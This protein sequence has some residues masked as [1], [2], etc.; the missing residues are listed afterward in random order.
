[1]KRFKTILMTSLITSAVTIFPAAA[2]KRVTVTQ[3]KYAF[4]GDSVYVDM[5]IGL[6]DA[7][8]PANSY[9]LLTPTIQLD[10]IHKE[11][12]SVI[13][14]G[15]KRQKAYE[16]L[17]ALN[18]EPVGAGLVIHPDDNDAHRSYNYSVAVPFEPWMKEADFALREDQ[19]ECNGPLVKMRFDLIV[20]RMQDLNAPEEPKQLFFMA[21]FKAP[22]PEPVK[23]RSEA[24]TAYLDFTLGSSVLKSDFSNN[25][26][27]L[28]K[29]DQMIKTV[30]N[31]P[32]ITITQIIIDGYSS[33]DGP[34][35]LNLSLSGMRAD[36]L[37]EYVSST[38]KLD[39]SLI[40]VTEYG[41]DWKTFEEL[42]IASEVDYKE[43]VLEIINNTDN[44]D[45]RE[46]KLKALPGGA[47]ADI[48]ANFFPKSRRSDYELH[49]IVIPFTVEEGKK[50]IESNPKLLSLN[51]MFLIAASYPVNSDEFHRVF[52]IAAKTYPN[53]DIA[54]IN[55]AA[56][57]LNSK[58]IDAAQNFLQKVVNHDD[59]AYRNNLGMLTAMQGKYDEAAVHFRKAID[60]GND[61]ASKNL[62]EIA[63]KV[64]KQLAKK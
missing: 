20:G 54:N 64:N 47:Y 15:T 55:A 23:L 40:R 12:P 58:D 3:N 52:D 16:R 34:N 32:S 4:K 19:C 48:L 61:E 10:S 62:A 41:E 59:A 36:A 21:S 5:L 2:Q 25:S 13:I 56:N 57:A 7:D 9:V 43:Q 14:N 26:A 60:G 37:K 53:S 11:L 45:E 22:N 30:K 1:M 63:D 49:Y 18:R 50:K 8:I 44:Y 39:K 31:D 46:R 6:N 33:P 42:I 27:E 28:K 24:G 51:E 29:I 17:I 38:Y 35:A